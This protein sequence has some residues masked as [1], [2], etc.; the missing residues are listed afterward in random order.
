MGNCR[1]HTYGVEYYLSRT[2]DLP[3]S[4]NGRDGVTTYLTLL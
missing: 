3:P 4:A 1:L 2:G